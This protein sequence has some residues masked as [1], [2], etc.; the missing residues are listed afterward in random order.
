M[1]TQTEPK[2]TVGNRKIYIAAIFLIALVLGG[3]V[4]AL[5]LPKTKTEDVNKPYEEIITKNQGSYIVKNMI[6]TNASLDL[7]KIEKVMKEI[8]SECKKPCKINLYSDRAA[9][10][11]DIMAGESNFD[12]F[13]DQQRNYLATHILAFWGIDEGDSIEYYPSK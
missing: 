6:Y 13:T 2:G 1:E 11:L 3:V 12:G 7:T 10:D 4:L 9:Y 5:R 8:R